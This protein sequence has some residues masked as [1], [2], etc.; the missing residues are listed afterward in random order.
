MA[1]A[2]KVPGKS[3]LDVEK[4][5]ARGTMALAIAKIEAAAWLIDQVEVGELSFLGGRDSEVPCWW[6]TVEQSRAD[7]AGAIEQIAVET[8]GREVREI[9]AAIRVIDL[10]VL[11]ARRGPTEGD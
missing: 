11:G 1:R 6:S 9:R 10:E 3:P 4:N 5:V 8:I 7:L 2:A